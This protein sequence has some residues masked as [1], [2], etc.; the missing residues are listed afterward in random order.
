MERK[1]RALASLQGL[2]IGDAFGECFFLSIELLFKLQRA[3]LIGPSRFDDEGDEFI[4]EQI[5]SMRE[6]P[7]KPPWRW[8]DDTHMALG[9]VQILNEHGS[10]DQDALA[11]RFGKNYRL[12]PARGYGPAMHRLLPLLAEGADWQENAKSLFYG[13]GSFGN[14]AAMRAAPIGAHFADDLDTVAE[15]ARKASEITHAHE[16]GIAGGIAVALA[17]AIAVQ[18]GPAVSNAGELIEAV[19]PR[20]PNGAVRNGLE[21]ARDLPGYQ[22]IPVDEVAEELGNGS[23][24]SAQ[25]TVPFVLW[26]AGQHM[27]NYEEALW[28]TVSGLGDRDTTCAM[29]G[30][31]VALSTQ[32]PIPAAWLEA[33]EPLPEVG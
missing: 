20:V 1:E 16:E 4:I 26:C 33:R 28:L 18:N 6:V 11:Q 5:I 7:V 24:I 21:K 31:I 19:L 23:G 2:S 9:I 15:Q 8:T 10:I 17:A 13:D 32:T 3:G 29:V 25:D 12:E 14:G 30:G 22:E 27:N